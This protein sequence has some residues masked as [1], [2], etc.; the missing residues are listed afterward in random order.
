MF[1]VMDSD[2]MGFSWSSL[3]MLFIL[4]LDEQSFPIL[5]IYSISQQI[6]QYL[7][8]LSYHRRKLLT[9]NTSK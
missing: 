9:E 7:S 8:T 1:Q 4:E 3:S 2:Q 5:Q 6:T